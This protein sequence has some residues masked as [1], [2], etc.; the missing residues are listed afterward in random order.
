MSILLPYLKTCG[1][2]SEAIAN[3]EVSW[4]HE[5]DMQYISESEARRLF[6]IWKILAYGHGTHTHGYIR[7][8]H[9]VGVL[10]LKSYQ[11]FSNLK[12]NTIA[13][14]SKSVI[15]L[16]FCHRASTPILVTQDPSS[17]FS[18]RYFPASFMV[19]RRTDW[20]GSVRGGYRCSFERRVTVFNRKL[21]VGIP[22]I[23]GGIS[24]IRYYPL[25]RLA[26]KK[27]GNPA[28]NRKPHFEKVRTNE[29][30]TT[31]FVIE[32]IGMRQIVAEWKL[33]VWASRAWWRLKQLKQLRE[34]GGQ[35][36]MYNFKFS[37]ANTRFG[38]A[39]AC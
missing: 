29:P 24:F 11:L 14:F 28:R 16:S 34:M 35:D 20:L 2:S 33:M 27:F 39:N 23:R 12:R 6:P 13:V 15:L 18:Q 32:K 21:I 3:R 19:T 22:R 30:K 25:L 36:N 38:G 26:G 5:P 10:H 31:K 8:A 7:A 9:L 37:S 4:F 17:S 1:L